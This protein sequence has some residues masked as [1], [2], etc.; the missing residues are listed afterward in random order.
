[1]YVCEAIRRFRDTL[2]EKTLMSEIDISIFENLEQCARVSLAEIVQREQ[3]ATAQGKLVVKG[4]IAADN[5]PKRHDEPQC[6]NTIDVDALLRVIAKPGKSDKANA[7]GVSLDELIRKVEALYAQKE[8]LHL[9]ASDNQQVEGPRAGIY[10]L[11]GAIYKL[12]VK[13]GAGRLM[14]LVKKAGGAVVDTEGTEEEASRKRQ[15]RE[16]DEMV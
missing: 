3:K 2:L 12:I 11:A 9:D 6:R 15:R 5:I 10:R 4:D 14:E 16:D 8:I 1:L 13:V 7:A